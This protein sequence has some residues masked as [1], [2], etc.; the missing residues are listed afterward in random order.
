MPLRR[1]TTSLPSFSLN[2]T[3][4]AAAAA[5]A[6]LVMLS[7]LGALS[8]LRE[9]RLFYERLEQLAAASRNIERTNALIYAVVM[10]SRGIY[11]SLDRNVARRYADAQLGKLAQLAKVVAEWEAQVTEADAALFAPFRMR[12]DQFIAFRTEMARRTISIGSSAARELGDNDENR[13]VRTALNEDLEKLS[14]LYAARTRELG[15]T[16]DARGVASYFLG[17]LG[18][19]I[20]A[21]I[22]AAALALRW[23]VLMPLL[24][25]ARVTD[26]IAAGR[27]KLKIPHARRHDEIGRVAQAVETYQNGAFRLQELEEHEVEIERQYT[28]ILRQ[29][30]QLE[31]GAISSQQR[32]DAAVA[33]MAQGLIMLDSFGYVLMVNEQ[34]RKLYGVPASIAKPG[35]HV[36][37]ILAHRAKLGLLREKPSDF[38]AALRQRMKEGRA[39]IV[40]VELA[41]GRII[42]ISERPMAG[43]GWIATHEDFTAQRRN[44]RILAR[45]EYFLAALLENI[46]QA[47]VAKDAQSLRYVFVNRATE[48]LF[49][50]PRAEI[51]G[52]AARDLFPEPT[53]TLIE[54]FDRQ[55]LA[56]ETDQTPKAHSVEMP[57]NRIRDV[58]VRR[59]PISIGEG[60]P[61]FLLNIIE[62]RT[63]DQ[64]AAA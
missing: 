64:R 14:R 51:I 10:E 40:E 6:V 37:E 4:S 61:K 21:L 29:H 2:D 9:Q 56:D 54:T 41:D 59:L 28:D 30:E 11:M 60:E 31:Q 39:E 33:N 52:R 5:F 20:V 55:L 34:Y 32:L 12:I 15:E 45:A 46:P 53:C 50:L 19:L 25:I 62:D 27:I 43:G 22:A 16:A 48:V 44:E 13:A 17:G 1:F 58:V 35:A 7:T 24:D 23:G 42:R 18:L 36:R 57:G 63:A 47:V 3:I 38:L 8:A 49:G 26:R